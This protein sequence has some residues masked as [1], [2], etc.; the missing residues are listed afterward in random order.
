MLFG[1][2]FAAA[3][4]ASERAAHQ[5]GGGNGFGHNSMIED[6]RPAGGGYL[7]EPKERKPKCARCRNHGIVAWLK[8][9]K[10]HCKYK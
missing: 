2:V 10:R 3:A 4:A 1:N 8:G 9:H 6:P 5:Q 7:I